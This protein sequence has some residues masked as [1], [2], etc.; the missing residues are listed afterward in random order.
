[1]GLAFQASDY[2]GELASEPEKT[3]QPLLPQPGLNAGLQSLRGPNFLLLSFLYCAET[4]WNQCR[5]AFE[6]LL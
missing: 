4:K 5:I 3:E 6:W 2:F 1:M